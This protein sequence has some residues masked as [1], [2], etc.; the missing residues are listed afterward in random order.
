VIVVEAED[1]D[2]MVPANV[3]TL[4]HEYEEMV[5]PT[6]VPDPVRVTEDVGRVIV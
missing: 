5:P 6:S 2:V 3:D 4:V 1:G